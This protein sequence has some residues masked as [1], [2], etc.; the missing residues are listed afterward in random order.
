MLGFKVF[1]RVAVPIV[2]VERLHRIRK[3][4]L[5]PGRLRVAGQA[6]P[7]IWDAALSA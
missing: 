1:G 7:A 6:A 4:Q 5:K 2:S 3:G